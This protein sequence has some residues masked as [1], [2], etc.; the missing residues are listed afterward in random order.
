MYHCIN[1]NLFFELVQFSLNEVNLSTFI[2]NKH[3]LSWFTFKSLDLHWHHFGTIRF[4]ILFEQ[5]QLM[6]D[7]TQTISSKLTCL[8]NQQNSQATDGKSGRSS[9]RVSVQ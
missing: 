7:I 3:P 1:L 4:A 6:L 2:L 5:K 8:K 9:N